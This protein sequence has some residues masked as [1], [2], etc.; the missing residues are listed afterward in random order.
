MRTMR[1][2]RR[3][4]GVRLSSRA[5][6]HPWT[7]IA[8]PPA[9]AALFARAP[10]AARPSFASDG[11]A[12]SLIAHIQKRPL[13]IDSTTIHIFQYISTIDRG[14]RSLRTKASPAASTTWHR[15]RV[16]GAPDEEVVRPVMA[17]IAAIISIDPG[18][19]SARAAQ[20]QRKTIVK[21]HASAAGGT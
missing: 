10:H 20:L 14:A 2:G 7:V 12:P 13:P 9:D 21:F 4:T 5:R 11:S 15:E 19:C 18:L 8:S 1:R 17:A 16:D 3:P 6:T